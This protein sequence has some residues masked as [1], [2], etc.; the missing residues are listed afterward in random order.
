M[1]KDWE[2]LQDIFHAA[3]SL[4]AQDR[5]AFLARECAEDEELRR[6]VV[7]L[8]EASEK[9]RDFMEQSAFGIGMQVLATEA[10]RGLAGQTIGSFKILS[11][12]GN[13]GMGDIYLAEDT[14]LG[15]KVAL[16]FLSGT[17]AENRWAKR[18]F[19]KE[20]QAVA[21]LDHPNICAIYGLEE[22]DG[23]SFIAMQYVEGARL[24]Q[25][26]EKGKLELGE[27][28]RLSIQ[29]A[30]ALSDAHEH[31]II[32]RDI[33]PL[34]IMVT[35]NRQVKVLDF[36]LAKLVPQQG[37]TKADELS[38]NSLQLGFI[39]GTIAFMS[40]EQMRGERLDYR[41]D[42]FSLG[43]VLYEMVSGRNP[44]ARKSKAE[45]ITSVLGSRPASL[46]HGA[47]QVP[48][49]L[50]RIVQK[51]LEKDRDERYQSAGEL[52][53]DLEALRKAM[54][55]DR[56]RPSPVYVRALAAATL[57]L[58]LLTVTVFVYGYLAKPR[59][60]AILPIANETGDADLDYMGD[61]V[62]DG[63]ISKLSGLT[64]LRVKAF[65]IITHYK[66]R[67]LDPV[68]AGKELDVDA[69]VMGRLTGTKESLKLQ[70]VMIDASD[71][72]QLWERKYPL[73]LEQLIEVEDDISNQLVSK[74][75][76]WPDRDE[77]RISRKP[78]PSDPR[79]HEQFMLGRYYWRVR[80]KKTIPKAIEHFDKA[81]S[82]DPL[83]ARAYAGLA[84]CY[85]LLNTVHYG[86]METKEAMTKAEA[87]AREAIEL[88]DNLPEAH[89]SL[90]VVYWKWHLNW[91]AAEAE[92]KRAIEIDPTYALAHYSYSILLSIKGRHREATEEGEIAKT[93][94][95]L[96]PA[97]GLNYCRT[98]YLARDYERA[99]G[100][101]ERLV[102]EQPDYANH[103]YML[104]LVYLGRGM[105]REATEIFEKLYADDKS[106]AGAAL[107]HAYG[108][109]GQRADALRVISELKE[110]Q[111][112]E[113]YISPQE[114]AIIYIGLG[115]KD[116][117]FALLRQAAD[118]RFAP[119][120]S[121][122][123]DPVFDRIRSDERFADL[124]A[125]LKLTSRPGE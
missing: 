47:P 32:H 7:S 23:H 70:V 81:I 36:G 45:T 66:G 46:R 108:V 9:R 34:N 119:L 5:G 125:R 91:E 67:Q 72:S 14:Q 69:V 1:N 56:R 84:D 99:S 98:F 111:S 109:S 29:I 103:R 76:L 122:G 89:T 35:P 15:R 3:L 20:A 121:I 28:V 101:F 123:V 57:L 106:M 96:S 55:G 116:Q 26:I 27:V 44:F 65:N 115:E 18:Q 80:D 93:H 68:K 22:V 59:A 112:D 24:D 82:F 21:M 43:V 33:K 102:R 54:D 87:A 74:L 49:E 94:D 30:G 117:A 104:G 90:G 42:I 78:R 41:T 8:V 63:L 83:Y 97:T 11:V 105:V 13:G 124:A 53:G 114:L 86:A 110:L 39:P 50:D 92:F 118:E 52:L 40:P 51:C 25:L 77:A 12:L 71:G 79:A 88:D 73:R 113:K 85:L 19:M 4:K 95:A 10:T 2:R 120:A 60:L 48:R 17:L 38:S 100:C 107:G 58:L 75:E 16:K 62:T 37:L 64:K 61:G 31:G 6:E